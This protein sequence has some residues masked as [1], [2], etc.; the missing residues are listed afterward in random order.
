MLFLIIPIVIFMF[1]LGG[2]P[3][4]FQENIGTVVVFTNVMILINNI[5]IILLYY[6][7]KSLNNKIEGKEA[8]DSK[9]VDK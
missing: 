7:I 1:L 9:K 5:L 4:L 6:K 3:I 2:L 8:Y